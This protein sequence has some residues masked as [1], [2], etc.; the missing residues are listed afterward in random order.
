M[1]TENR[2]KDLIHPRELRIPVAKAALGLHLDPLDSM[3]RPVVAPLSRLPRQP[4]NK[5][6]LIASY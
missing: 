4:N 6:Q 1:L 2:T 5:S 3:A